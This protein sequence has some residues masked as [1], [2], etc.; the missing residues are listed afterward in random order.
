[1]RVSGFRFKVHCGTV[2]RLKGFWS[3]I[4]G[5]WFL[6]SGASNQIA[7][8]ILAIFFRGSPI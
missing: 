7:A 5:F 6:V 4:S 2:Y 3:L 1:M 8:S